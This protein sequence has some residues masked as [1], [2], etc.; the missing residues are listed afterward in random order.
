[1]MREAGVE[2][3]A[4]AAWPG[5]NNR[6]HEKHL[7]VDGRTSIE[8]GMN[9][10]DEYALGGSKA[11]VY[12]RGNPEGDLP[13]RDTDVELE[14]PAVHDAQRAFISNWQAAGGVIDADALAGLL[15]ELEPQPDDTPVRVVQNRPDREAEDRVLNLYLA[16]IKAA[17]HSIT[18][19]N[20]YLVPPPALLEALCEAARRGVDVRVMTNS[21]ESNDTKAVTHA[22]RHFYGALLAAGVKLFERQGGTLHSKTATFDGAYSIVGSANLNGRS[23]GLDTEVSLAVRSDSVAQQ[24]EQRF[25][26]GLEDARP[27]TLEQVERRPLRRRLKEWAFSTLAW[28]F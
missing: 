1:M 24:L 28:T 11:L 26:S 21:L 12:S 22:S 18:I 23:R 13:W 25:E 15:P 10:A 2:L 17:R 5:L 6:L 7:I 8:G 27:V 19:E 20:A 16:A 3:R 14:G 9:I 4:Y